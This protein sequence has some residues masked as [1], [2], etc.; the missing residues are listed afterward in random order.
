[1][2]LKVLFLLL[3]V[4]AVLQATAQEELP[5]ES[6]GGFDK[7]KLFF[8]GNFGASFGDYTLVNVSPQLGYRFNTFFAAGAGVN[9]I[10]NS[11]K[12]RDLYNDPIYRDNYGVAGLNV[13][14]RVYPLNVVMLQVQPE[15]N[16]TW[17]KRK[18]FDGL[19][20][21]KL[22][23]KFVPSLLLGAGAAIPSGPGA[24]M[25]MMQYDVLQHARSPY[26]TRPF[27]SFGYNMGF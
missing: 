26:G 15:M 2:K 8:G 27:L 19:P 21:A 1:M 11:Y 14:G 17:G 4:F 9:F 5:G 24:F 20:E 6:E 16:Y 18:Y 22:P 25:V 3:S 12:Q 10:Y 23:K 13:F 7:S